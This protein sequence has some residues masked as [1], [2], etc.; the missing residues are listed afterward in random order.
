MEK[1]EEKTK[2]EEKAEQE[3]PVEP[4]SVTLAKAQSDVTMA[5]LQIQNTYG[6]P[7]YLMALLVGAALGDIRECANKELLNA[8]ETVKK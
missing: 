1:K 5:I 7:A 8:M 4:I 6:L 3:L 2:L